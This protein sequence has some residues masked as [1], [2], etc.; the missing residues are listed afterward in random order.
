MSI[1]TIKTPQKCKI[2]FE[3][4]MPC[5]FLQEWQ[6]VLKN[7]HSKVFYSGFLTIPSI[8]RS[9]SLIALLRKLKSKYDELLL[10]SRFFRKC[11]H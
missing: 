8:K 1:N 9:Y 10:M 5:V 2:G 6:P 4:P 7:K 11:Y 3:V